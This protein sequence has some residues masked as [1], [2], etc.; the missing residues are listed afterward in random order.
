ML[1]RSF[2]KA[3]LVTGMLVAFAG[4]AGAETYPQD[5]NGWSIGFGAGG[6][7][8]GLSLDGGGSSD[9]EGGVTGN[10][11]LG[12]PLNPNV[13]LAL[14]SALW[15]KTQN[16]ATV[17]FSATTVG[18]ALFPSE[19][20]VIRGGIGLGSTTVSVDLG[21]PTVSQTENGFGIHGAVGYEFR[22]TKTFALGPQADFGYTT[23]DGGSANWFGGGINF[24]WYFLSAK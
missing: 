21:G 3:A 19:G 10:F 17:T 18:V 16:S 13:S 24:N 5:H 7:T 8:A 4:I 6:G 11:R 12:Y 1:K 23:F 22:L 15:S 9:R 20:L 14:E 2:V